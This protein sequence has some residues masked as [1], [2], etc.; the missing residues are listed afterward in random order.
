[1][2]RTF[3]AMALIA[4][5]S[6]CADC[7][8]DCSGECIVERQNNEAI[9]QR[10]L[11]ETVEHVGNVDEAEIGILVRDTMQKYQSEWNE[12][13]VAAY[14]RLN[15][16]ELDHI[17]MFEWKDALSYQEL[18]DMAGAAENLEKYSLET[19]R[20]LFRETYLEMKMTLKE[21]RQIAVTGK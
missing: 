9:F 17:C 19:S 11:F 7:T 2:N 14:S 3:P 20:D 1:M 16:A 18:K 12:S 13:Q 21:N 15:Q 5:L 4:M 6:A 10:K 8:R